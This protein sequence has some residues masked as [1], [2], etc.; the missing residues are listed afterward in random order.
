V[1]VVVL[2]LL[3]RKPS[4]TTDDNE[5]DYGKAREFPDRPSSSS[6]SVCWSGKQIDHDERRR[7]RLSED[8]IGDWGI[9]LNG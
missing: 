2:G 9:T 3:V 5:N 4:T 8:A 1:V 6:S 7:E